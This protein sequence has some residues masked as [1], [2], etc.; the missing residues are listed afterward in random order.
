MSSPSIDPAAAGHY[1]GLV[2]A[3]LGIVLRIVL[4]LLLVRLVVRA[5]APAL[6]RRPRP[7]PQP[8]R[9]VTT[10]DLVRDFVCNTFVPRDRAVRA[11]IAG[12]EQLFCSTACAERA[13]LA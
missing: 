5:V 10:G 13:R 7:E 2:L 12:E 3:V 9:T 8:R 4:A 11:V 1:P 6:V